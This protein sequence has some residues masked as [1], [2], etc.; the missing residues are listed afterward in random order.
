MY[1]W[2]KPRQLCGTKCNKPVSQR[3]DAMNGLI[4]IEAKSRM[5][6]KTAACFVGSFTVLVLGA[7]LVAA[8][9]FGI[10]ALTER[11]FFEKYI[12]AVGGLPA[13]LTVIAAFA[14]IRFFVLVSLCALHLGE[15][16]YYINICET[17]TPC[18]S[19]LFS[20]CKPK[21][22]F[23]AFRLYAELFAL[24]TAWFLFFIT[25][26]LLCGASAF[27]TVYRSAAFGVPAYILTLAA[28]SLTVMGIMF[29]YCISRRYRLCSYIAVK[30]EELN[31][32]EII[33][34]SV[35]ITDGS[36]ADAAL[37]GFSMAGWRLLSL[38]PF[39]FIYALPYCKI[40]YAQFNNAVHKNETVKKAYTKAR[41][42]E[43]HRHF[44][45]QAEAPA[46]E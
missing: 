16:A 25:P 9:V 22:A 8:A 5:L 28:V 7:A 17:G 14:V 37:F 39:S 3:E 46:K 26:A 10:Y 45:R 18:F 19:Q 27:F 38:L 20:Y 24:K 44:P 12:E 35:E 30:N 1:L 6:G 42:A 41:A 40:A 15:S 21:K 43:F 29:F 36:L 13:N 34:Q 32:R 11:D 2:H 23:R 31:A 4:K 33:R